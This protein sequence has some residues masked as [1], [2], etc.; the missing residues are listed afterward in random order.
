MITALGDSII[1]GVVVHSDGST[2]L[3]QYRVSSKT[4]I[5]YCAQLLHT[6]G[7]N[8]GRFGCTAPVGERVAERNM[9]KLRA[10]KI[11]LIE[12]GGNDSDYDWK[13]IATNP[14][15]CF[16]PRTELDAFKEAYKHIITCVLEAGAMPVV[17]SLPPMDAAMYFDFFTKGWDSQRITNVKQWLGDSMAKMHEGHALYNR[18][19]RQIAAELGVQ[20][21]DIATPFMA[22]SD[23]QHYLCEDGIHPTEAGQARIAEEIVTQLAA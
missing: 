22:Q 1:K 15:G 7:M 10:S 9:D 12:Y 13:A 14:H 16:A 19:T 3:R 18:T 11:V 6:E 2:G 23:W 17:L 20:F 8:L 4:I 5:D 21:I